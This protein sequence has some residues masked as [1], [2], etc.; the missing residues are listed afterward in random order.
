MGCPPGAGP[1]RTS[2]IPSK[3]QS[4]R[5]AVSSTAATTAVQLAAAAIVRSA[6]RDARLGLDLASRGLQSCA[7]GPAAGAIITKILITD[8][9]ADAV[10]ATPWL[11][12]EI[13]TT[14]TQS[15]SEPRGSNSRS[16]AT[17]AP[18]GLSEVKSSCLRRCFEPRPLA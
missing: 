10:F 5:S 9:Q 13:F 2:A 3:T 1:L 7:I 17:S 15:I 6:G 8:D 18:D 11:A 12:G 16:A 4:N 14:S